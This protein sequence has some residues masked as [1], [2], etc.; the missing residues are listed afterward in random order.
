MGK[1][2]FLVIGIAILLCRINAYAQPLKKEIK[3]N[4][5]ILASLYLTKCNGTP[6]DN[7]K[8]KYDLNSDVYTHTEC[9]KITALGA[10]SV[11]VYLSD[12]FILKNKNGA[13]FID[14][15]VLIDNQSLVEIP[16]D[17]GDYTPINLSNGET[18]V[19]LKINAAPPKRTLAGDIY[20]GTAKLVIE[21]EL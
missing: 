18:Y 5:E 1:K 16:S 2:I 8:L 13:E 15:E 14:H 3:V 6:L 9:I 17:T 21:E 4:A 20:S 12:R 10:D 19:E 11:N 7:V